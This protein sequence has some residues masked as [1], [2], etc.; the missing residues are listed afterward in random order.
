MWS[1]CKGK[2]VKLS[3]CVITTSCSRMEM[4]RFIIIIIIIIIGVE[5]LSP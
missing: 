4:P 2:Y 5:V 3:V 1:M